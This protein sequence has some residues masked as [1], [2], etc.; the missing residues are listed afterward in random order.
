[1]K[2]INTQLRRYYRQIRSWLPCDRKQKNRCI[3][4][5]SESMIGFLE[6]KPNASFQDIVDRFGTPQQIASAFI[7][8]TDT[9]KLLHSL[10]IR[11]RI[12]MWVAT[13]IIAA[14]LTLA[15]GLGVELYILD[16][17]AH[18]YVITDII[19]SDPVLIEDE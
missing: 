10:K 2:K 4:E 11:K 8:E 9:Q 3:Q 6:Q 13:G 16:D 12:V 7:E 15:V 17:I 1:M 5:L 18:G 14:L 19:E